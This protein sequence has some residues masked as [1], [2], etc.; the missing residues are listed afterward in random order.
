MLTEEKKIDIFNIVVDI[1]EGISGDWKVERF[2]VSEEDARFH[3]I[4]CAIGFGQRGREV[5]PGTYTR[6]LRKGTV[7]M[8]DTQ[9]ERWDHYGCWRRSQG[10]VLINGLGLGMIVKAMMEKPE[11]TSV[12]VIEIS[13][14]VVK[15]VGTHLLKQYPDRLKIIVADALEYKPPKGVTYD[16]VW[17]DIWDEI[18]SDNL[19]TMHKLHRKWGR[20]TDAQ[21]SWCR[22]EC[23]RK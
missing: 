14:D 4:R 9:A 8:S 23:E 15:L 3:N 17:H 10:D 6:L 5:K 2:V 11:V 22:A 21:E 16:Y 18:C 13:K 19:P 20:R 12:T 7:V 1:P